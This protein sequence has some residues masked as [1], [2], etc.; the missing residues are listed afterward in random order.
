MIRFVAT[1]DD[2][3]R[4]RF[5]FSP[6]GEA[7][8]SIRMMTSPARAQL[9]KP[10]VDQVRPPLRRVDIRPLRALIPPTGYV[11]DFLT[12]P[13]APGRLDFDTHL[14]IVRSTDAAGP[15][16]ASSTR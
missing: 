14:E 10:W 8:F 2:M 13:P 5:A 3:S 9:H 12:P 7:V 11:P 15:D 4:V 6:L 16:G 1:A